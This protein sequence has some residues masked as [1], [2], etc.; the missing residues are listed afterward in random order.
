MG[1]SEDHC[2]LDLVE[3]EDFLGFLEG[4][5]F[6]AETKATAQYSCVEDGRVRLEVL[7][8]S[9]LAR[10][11]MAFTDEA[12]MAFIDE[13]LMVEA[14]LSSLGLLDPGSQP[15]RMLFQNDN[16]LEFLGNVEKDPSAKEV[17]ALAEE[18]E[19]PKA[20]ELTYVPE[21]EVLDSLPSNFVNFNSF[22]GLPV[23]GFEKEINSLLKKLELRKGR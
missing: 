8:K 21:G 1:L 6:F 17:V 5:A 18:V 3:E 20:L 14:S 7:L 9:V 23:K 19:P 22:L 11:R 13:A 10:S 16:L 12:L 2:L 15:L 4:R